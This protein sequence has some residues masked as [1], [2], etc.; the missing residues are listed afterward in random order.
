MDYPAKS[1]LT[2]DIPD[3]DTYF[4]SLAFLIS[5]RSKDA[6]SQCGCVLV[7]ENNHIVATGYNSFIAGLPDNELPN[8]RP[9]KYEWMLHAEEAA[10]AH[11]NVNPWSKQ[12]RAYLT[13]PPCFR[14]LQRLANANITTIIHCDQKLHMLSVE[15]LENKNKRDF[16][17]KAKKMQ[18]IQKNLDPKYLL[19]AASHVPPTSV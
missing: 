15:K 6:Q 10:M 12:I 19:K 16:V 7:D 5:T 4:L 8:V 18:I 2:I 1:K 3:W 14:C 9:D 17:V 13:G 11:M